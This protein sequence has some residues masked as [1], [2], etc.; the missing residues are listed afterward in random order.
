MKSR[1][2]WVGAVLMA[3]CGM[4]ALPA[5]ASEIDLTVSVPSQAA[6]GGMAQNHLRLGVEPGGTD[7]FDTSWDAVAA[8]PS[9]VLTAVIRH[10]SYPAGRQSLWWD[11]RGDTFP[12]VWD[13]EVTSDQADAAISLSW[14]PPSTV[15]AQCAQVAWTLQDALT[16]QTDDLAA[17]P[18]PYSFTNHVGTPHRFIVTAS[19]MPTAT[20]PPPP[21]NLWSPRQGRASVYLA[22]SGPR[23]PGLRYHLYRED[24]RGRV[25]VTPSPQSATSYV[26]T[27]LDAKGAMTYRVTAVDA[28]GCESPYSAETVIAPRR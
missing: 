5:H 18:L 23:D 19:S 17:S 25:R 3:G 4:M 22:W 20:P 14:T 24:D 13:I 9:D 21:F 28:R 15:A 6:E 2:A 16:G 11:V 7:N 10:P 1:R 12:Q 8:F 27:G 26:D